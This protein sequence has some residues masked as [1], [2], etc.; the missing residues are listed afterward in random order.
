M[1]L[2]LGSLN[3]RPTS[4]TQTGSSAPF[5]PVAITCGLVPPSMTPSIAVDG[6]RGIDAG[7][8]PEA[9]ALSRSR[10]WSASRTKRTHAASTARGERY[11]R[12]EHVMSWL[13]T[14]ILASDSAPSMTG[15]RV[16]RGDHQSTVVRRRSNRYDRAADALVH[17]LVQ[18]AGAS[19]SGPANAAEVCVGVA[20]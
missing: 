14:R 19:G 11:K 3:K 9:W 17:P 6:C 1:R 13:G 15:L 2:A 20:G 10:P 4:G 16:R 7:G 8:G 12:R 5:N 18:R